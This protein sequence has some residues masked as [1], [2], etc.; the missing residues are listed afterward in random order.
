MAEND[1]QPFNWV[2]SARGE[3]EGQEKEKTAREVIDEAKELSLKGEHGQVISL[4]AKLLEKYEE[5]TSYE[6]MQSEDLLNFSIKKFIEK[7]R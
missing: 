7:R 2:K 3:V 1:K 6:L 5:L 4:I